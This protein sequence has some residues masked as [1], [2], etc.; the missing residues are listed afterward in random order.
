MV[1]ADMAMQVLIPDW[2]KGQGRLDSGCWVVELVRLD[3]SAAEFARCGRKTA[4][5]GTAVFGPLW[6]DVAVAVVAR[7]N[8]VPR[9]NIE[10][11]DSWKMSCASWFDLLDAT[12][13]VSHSISGFRT[14]PTMAIPNALSPLGSFALTI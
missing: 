2:A 12:W 10:L 8:V 13:R 3:D 9:A 4:L 14:P 11:L 1:L 6:P 5:P 7:R